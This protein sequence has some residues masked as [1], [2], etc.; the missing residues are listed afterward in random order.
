MRSFDVDFLSVGQAANLYFQ[1][2]KPEKTTESNKETVSFQ[3]VLNE[4][5]KQE[6]KFSKHA[7]G[8]LENRNIE[9]SE[10]QLDRLNQGVG[11]AR[12]KQIQESLV[13]LDNLAF[14][15][16]VKNN[17]VVTAMEQG[18]SGQVFTNIDGAVI[19]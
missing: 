3:D 15:V 4:K 16:N 2:L 12:T 7:I 10:D 18:E 19:V 5:V 6:E 9:L 14:I 13:I 17:T 8:R 11:Q 1:N